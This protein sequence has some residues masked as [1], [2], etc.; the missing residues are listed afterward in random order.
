[1]SHSVGDSTREIL[2]CYSWFIHLLF[3]KNGQ[4]KNT[5]LKIN[6]A[7]LN[8]RKVVLFFMKFILNRELRL[9]TA[10]WKHL[11]V[12]IV[13]CRDVKMIACIH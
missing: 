13:L 11:H 7:F 10:E 4:E 6:V 8:R 2:R 9:H 1:M 5:L 12:A 3:F